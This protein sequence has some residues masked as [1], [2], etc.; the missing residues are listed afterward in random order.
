MSCLHDKV[1][2]AAAEASDY[3][4]PSQNKHVIL[5]YFLAIFQCFYNSSV[6][7]SDAVSF[8]LSKDATPSG[9]LDSVVKGFKGGK[10]ENDVNPLGL[11]K[12][13]DAHLDSLF[14]YPPF[15][16]PSKGV[17]DGEDVI[18]LDIGSLLALLLYS[19][20]TFLFSF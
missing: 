8:L 3:F 5:F 4:Y 7:K 14:S 2:A 12:L 20:S 19:F 13:N 9:I 18:E 11:C 6:G 17:T 10:V 16:K 15:L 1:L